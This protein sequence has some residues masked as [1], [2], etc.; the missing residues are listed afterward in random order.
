MIEILKILGG[1]VVA[2]G[3]LLLLL[4]VLERFDAFRNRRRNRRGF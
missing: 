3:V 4:V 2:C 1:M